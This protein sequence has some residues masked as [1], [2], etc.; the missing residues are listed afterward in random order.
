M[1]KKRRKGPYNSE[2][3]S[4]DNNYVFYQRLSD[5]DAP[6][7]A[8]WNKIYNKSIDRFKADL[9]SITTEEVNS[10]AL[11]LIQQ[12]EAER[13]K[14]LQ[15]L[16]MMGLNTSTNLKDYTNYINVINK[17]IGFQDDYKNLLLLMN[18]EAVDKHRA[19]GAMSYFESELTTV[20]ATKIRQYIN[21]S[22]GKQAIEKIVEGDFTQWNKDFNIL[23]DQAIEQTF[24]KISNRTDKLDNGE[25]IQIWKRV[26][27]LLKQTGDQY[28]I[29]RSTIF[30]R[31]NLDK[32]K[33]FLDKWIVDQRDFQTKK[34]KHHTRGLNK[35]IRNSY[36]VD[37]I[38]ARSI[39]GFLEESMVNTLPKEIIVGG[40]KTARGGAVMGSNMM[41]TDTVEIFTQK[42]GINA[43]TLAEQFSQEITGNNNLE[44]ARKQIIDYY[45]NH[46]K[47]LENSFVVYGSSKL[48]SL[49][50]NF[51]GFSGHSMKGQQ[52]PGFFNSL[53]GNHKIDGWKVM[54]LLIN[55]ANNTI[56][57]NE[58]A[59]VKEKITTILSQHMAN[60][61]FDDWNTLGKENNN[62]IHIFTL[63]NIKVP[64]SVLL[65][66]AGVALQDSY[67]AMRQYFKVYFTLPQDVLYPTKV[68]ENTENTEG[69]TMQ[70]YWQEQ[71]IASLEQS[72]L[73]IKFLA[74][75][76]TLL[77]ELINNL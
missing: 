12:G 73:G 23:I 21:S 49:G 4:Y 42:I 56:G 5:I 24:I 40:N 59:E 22:H 58:Q 1:G 48:Y 10:I 70:S 53:E 6:Q 14:E 46:L 65:I 64:L 41:K 55:C 32:T 17:L 26:S 60:L 18:K 9:N 68:G 33:Q 75:F 19:T 51:R 77:N 63:N 67:Q 16:Q 36:S 39:A 35:G 27:D 13:K 74:N 28:N 37:E 11:S 72:K 29:L 44:K 15:F 71:K 8:F 47:N 50:E 2:D 66:S 30:Q 43:Q 34:G 31:Y 69:R 76:K 61:L 52:I 25:E 20:I 57:E 54:R 45:E 7:A 3:F 38:T 62:A